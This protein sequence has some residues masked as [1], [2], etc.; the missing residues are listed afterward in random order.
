MD[1]ILQDLDPREAFSAWFKANPSIRPDG[2][3]LENIPEIS[4]Q[5][6]T[7]LMYSAGCESFRYCF[8]C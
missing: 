6:G 4:F 3:S 7:Y 2:R 8:F 5:L 1:V